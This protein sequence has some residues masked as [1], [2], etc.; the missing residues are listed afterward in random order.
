MV[1]QYNRTVLNESFDDNI[2]E[3]VWRKGK[4]APGHDPN[5]R[6][7]DICDAWIERK[8]Y[9]K[10]VTGG[11]GW[12][13]DHIKPVSSGG[14]DDLSNLQP[15]QWENNRAK[16]DHAPGEWT[17]AKSTRQSGNIFNR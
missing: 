6:R 15:L 2:V 12:E 14:T 11:T 17:C 1:Y 7:K 16:S 13:V 4:I 10:T 3:M 8:E 9:G 5:L